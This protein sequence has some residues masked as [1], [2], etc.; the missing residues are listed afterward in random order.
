MA[1]AKL[2]NNLHQCTF[3]TLTLDE[4]KCE[5]KNIEITEILEIFTKGVY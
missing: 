5:G 2:L 3:S 4:I 1:I